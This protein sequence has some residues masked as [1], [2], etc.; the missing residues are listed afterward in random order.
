MNGEFIVGTVIVL[1]LW[2]FVIL[3]AVTPW[4]GMSI[5][6]YMVI[7]TFLAAAFIL[8]IIWSYKSDAFDDL[9]WETIL[10]FAL[11]IA[12]FLV[13]IFV[14]WYFVRRKLK[15][16]TKHLTHHKHHESPSEHRAHIVNEIMGDEEADPPG[17]ER[18]IQTNIP[19]T[20]SPARNY[21]P[22]SSIKYKI[23]SSIMERE[24]EGGSDNYSKYWN[25]LK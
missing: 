18:D 1:V 9:S 16:F 6:P 15:S 17:V 8:F 23:P 20:P 4:C 21:S 19:Y 11:V 3:I 7:F 13:G 24:E 22:P 25:E 5:L 2:V 10:L 12:A 14:L